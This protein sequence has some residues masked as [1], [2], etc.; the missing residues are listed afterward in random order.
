[1]PLI[2][3]CVCV[4]TGPIAIEAGRHPVLEGTISEDFVVMCLSYIEVHKMKYF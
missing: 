2:D 4:E 3:F 1:M